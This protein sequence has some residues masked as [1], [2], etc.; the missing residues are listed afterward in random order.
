MGRLYPVRGNLL[1]PRAMRAPVNVACPPVGRGN[2]E[3]DNGILDLCIGI[4]IADR[5]GERELE[6][7]IS[8]HRQRVGAQP[9]TEKQGQP[10]I[11]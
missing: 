1:R 9:V 2:N 6:A 11:G 8:G 10:L 4:E 7:R 5:G 3:V